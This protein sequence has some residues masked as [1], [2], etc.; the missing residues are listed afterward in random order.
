LH[1]FGPIYEKLC[2]LSCRAGLATNDK[3]N[4]IGRDWFCNI[5][6][7]RDFLSLFGLGRLSWFSNVLIARHATG[8]AVFFSWGRFEKRNR[9]HTFLLEIVAIMAYLL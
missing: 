5:I 9:P 8:T 6:K 2:R 7:L 1:L 4:T 3:R